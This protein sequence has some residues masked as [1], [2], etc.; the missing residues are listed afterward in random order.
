MPENRTFN[1]RSLARLAVVAALYAALTIV[2]QPIS[3][4]LIQLR[5]SEILVLLCFY[6][7]DYLSLIHI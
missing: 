7:R 2:L 5:L 1:V 6:R 3:F 4:G